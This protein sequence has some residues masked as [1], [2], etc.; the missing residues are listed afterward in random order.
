MASFPDLS[1]LTRYSGWDAEA[2]AVWPF[3]LAV[4]VSFLT[5]V[6]WVSPCGVSHFTLSPDFRVFDDVTLRSVLLAA[7]G[8]AEMRRR[9]ELR[10]A[11]G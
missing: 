7:E 10:G 1:L 8:R 4:P 9:T 6:P 2:L 3:T 5:T 11:H